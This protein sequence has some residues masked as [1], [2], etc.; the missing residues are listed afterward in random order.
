MKIYKI[1]VQ[2]EMMAELEIEAETLEEAIALA[3]EYDQ[4]PPDAEYIDGSWEINY[5]MLEFLNEDTIN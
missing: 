4:E 1:P 2:Y 3:S 5:E